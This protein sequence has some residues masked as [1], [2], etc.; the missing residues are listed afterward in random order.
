[1]RRPSPLAVAVAVAA[2][3]LVA[4]AVQIDRDPSRVGLVDASQQ[5]TTPPSA[6]DAARAPL[7]LPLESAAGPTTA[8]L[9]APSWQARQGNCF[10][11]A[12]RCACR[13]DVAS[14]L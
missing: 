1:M 5:A 2:V 7:C 4:A 14:A 8:A 10:A 3:S 13:A 11:E 6:S 12:A 9:E